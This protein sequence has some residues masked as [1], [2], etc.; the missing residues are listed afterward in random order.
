MGGRSSRA[1]QRRPRC[2][3]RS[4]V[5][6]WEG[7]AATAVGEPQ[8]RGETLLS[9]PTSQ[10]RAGGWDDSC[11]SLGPCSMG[12]VDQGGPCSAHS[13]QRSV[14]Q[15]LCPWMRRAP[16]VGR[17]G[18]V[19]WGGPSESRFCVPHFC[20]ASAEAAGGG[21]CPATTFLPELGLGHVAR[22]PRVLDRLPAETSVGPVIV[23]RSFLTRPVVGSTLLGGPTPL[24]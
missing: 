4:C 7:S 22:G 23:L 2:L 17:G 21:G 18:A 20:R 6:W 14:A 15:P 11:G 13:H 5:R 8:L 9:R 3:L 16:W 12:G 19:G 1:L 24:S 10:P